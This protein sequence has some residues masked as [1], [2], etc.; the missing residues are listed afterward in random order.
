MGSPEFSCMLFLERVRV[1]RLRRTE[2]PPRN[3]TWWRVA[4]LHKN[5]VTVCCIGFSKLIGPATLMTVLGY[6]DCQLAHQCHPTRF[7]DEDAEAIVAY[8]RSLATHHK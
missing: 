7:N 1:L 3:L 5:G 4:F 8:L 2:Q 6:N